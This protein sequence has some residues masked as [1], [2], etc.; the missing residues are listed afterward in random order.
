MFINLEYNNNKTRASLHNIVHTPA[1]S[2][3]SIIPRRKSNVD[4]HQQAF[5]KII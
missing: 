5:E 1:E 3:A 4:E 2:N